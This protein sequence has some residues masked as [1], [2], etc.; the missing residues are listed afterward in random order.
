ML[1]KKAF[2]SLLALFTGGFVPINLIV[3]SFG[4]A[5]YFKK[6]TISLIY[7]NELSWAS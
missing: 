6:I 1:S 7:I 5:Q 2:L 4:Y 3:L